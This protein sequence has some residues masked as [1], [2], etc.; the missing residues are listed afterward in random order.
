M[1]R[2][3]FL[4]L[5][6]TGGTSIH[7][8]LVA[9]VPRERIFPWRFSHEAQQH[10]ARAP[11]YQVFSGHFRASDF[12]DLPGEVLR[13]TILREPVARLLSF[14]HF[15][16][17]HSREVV[18]RHQLIQPRIARERGLL[19]FLRAPEGAVQDAINNTMA[20]YL[21]GPYWTTVRDG[22]T[23]HIDMRTRREVSEMRI[24][25]EALR[26]LRHMHVFGDLSEIT[27]VYNTV[28]ED[29]GLPALERM[30]RDNTREDAAP[31]LEPHEEEAVPEEAME[32]MLRLTRLDRMIWELAP[33][34][35]RG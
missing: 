31:G 13:F 5:P 22:R 6:K 8:Q 27:R 34:F 20:R 26:N 32:E 33:R 35:S 11:D 18:E 29:F 21:A 30:P 24:I 3:I 23:I 4:H 9:A 15:C 25:E 28:A 19:G 17:R 2:L 7:N 10:A 12:A 1:R 16:R 14:Y